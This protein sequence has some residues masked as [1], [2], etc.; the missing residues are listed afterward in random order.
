MKRTVL[1]LLLVL[2]IQCAMVAVV[3]WPRLTGPAQEALEPLAAFASASID[4]IYV[5]DEYDNETM[6]RKTGDRWTL[7]EL[8]N[9]L[10]A[11]TSSDT[12]WPI[13]DS[14]AARQRFQVASYYYQRRIRLLENY[15]VLGSYFLGTSPGVRK[16]HIR[17][18][19]Q[20]AIYSIA[21]N[22]F[23]A[24]G[25]GG[26]WLDRKLLQVRT[27]LR[28]T[29]DTYSLHRQGSD[30]QSGIGLRPDERELEA[31]L[32]SLRSLQVDGIAN[33]DQQRDLAE[34][35]A[36]LV[37]EVESLTGTVTLELFTLGDR[38]FIHSS[39]YPLTFTVSAYDYERL[40]S[41]DF[42]LISGELPSG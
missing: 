5:G 25:H 9:L 22:A 23:D 41:I 16:I 28:I 15:A 20:D 10:A 42:R 11:I 7:P 29:A 21:F 32:T 1:T 39:E 17:N 31:L 2:A 30:W 27:P 35:E 33:P 38:Y 14:T 4:E 26:G 18:E 19:S 37:L 36:A 13:A 6:L 8:E 40:L 24:P 34:A 3:Y 12:D